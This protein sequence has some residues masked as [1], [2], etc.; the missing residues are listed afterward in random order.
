MK[1]VKVDF[2]QFADK[3]ALHAYLKE[4]L[5]FPA[6]YG[7][8]F[9]ALHDCLTD[10]REDT[11]LVL[12]HIQALERAGAICCRVIAQACEENEHLQMI[13]EEEKA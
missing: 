13:F 3:A 12:S 2:S 5:D 6:W 11:Q 8:N 4:Q 7:A 9:D 1:R 10:L